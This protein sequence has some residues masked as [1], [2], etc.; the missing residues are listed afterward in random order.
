VRVAPV[1]REVM[2]IAVHLM[3]R[4]LGEVPVVHDHGTLV[5]L[6]LLFLHRTPLRGADGNCRHRIDA[7]DRRD[8]RSKC[9]EFSTEACAAS[10]TDQRRLSARVGSEAAGGQSGIEL[11]SVFP[12]T[13]QLSVPPPGPGPIGSGYLGSR[14]VVG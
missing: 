13:V 6:G 4:E 8:L 1:E 2:W 5:L 14:T 12:P 3:L 9:Q 7:G 11:L 10:T